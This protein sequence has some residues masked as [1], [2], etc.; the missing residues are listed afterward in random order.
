MFG[1]YNLGAVISVSTSQRKTW[2]SM[3][4]RGRGTDCA[5]RSQRSRFA[6]LRIGK[7]YA[8]DSVTKVGSEHSHV[9]CEIFGIVDL[10]KSALTL[11]RGPQPA[12]RLRKCSGLHH[13]RISLGLLSE[14]GTTQP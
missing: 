9:Q 4:Q 14:L 13:K 2:S 10:A 3:V 7:C 12:G 11:T 1:S 6:R 8:I 5:H